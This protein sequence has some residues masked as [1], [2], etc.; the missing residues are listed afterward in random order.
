MVVSGTPWCTAGA[1]GVKLTVAFVSP[2]C[3]VGLLKLTVRS[4]PSTVAHGS[5]GWSGRV[6][7]VS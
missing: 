3:M 2:R 1:G 7:S 6:T 4:G 5:T